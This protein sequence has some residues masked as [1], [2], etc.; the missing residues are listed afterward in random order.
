MRSAWAIAAKEFRA[1]WTSPIAYAVV[2]IY[3]VITGTMFFGELFLVSFLLDFLVVT[4][5]VFG[6]LPPSPPVVVFLLIKMRMKGL[7]VL[8]SCIATSSTRSSIGL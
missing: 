6:I 1:Y 3:L 2:S 4:C 7:P 8:G 5:L